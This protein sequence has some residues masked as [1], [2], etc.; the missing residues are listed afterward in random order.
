MLEKNNLL[1]EEIYSFSTPN[2]KIRIWCEENIKNLEIISDFISYD[3]NNYKDKIILG[4]KILEFGQINAV[5]LINNFNGTGNV[6]YLN[7]P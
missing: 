4:K 3:S 6:I 7:W 2:W 5:E 1:I